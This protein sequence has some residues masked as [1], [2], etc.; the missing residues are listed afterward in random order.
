MAI[1]PP[2]PGT[3]FSGLSRDGSIILWVMIHPAEDLRDIW[4][5]HDLTFDVVTQGNSPA[6][7]VGKIIEASTL[8]ID[9]DQEHQYDPF[10][11]RAEEEF[12]DRLESVLGGSQH[13]EINALTEHVIALEIRLSRAKDGTWSSHVM[14]P[15]AAIAHK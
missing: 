15:V 12:W 14:S 2:L 11:R 5:A 3:R 4:I 6:D 10:K 9:W 1:P 13:S 7:A 8:V